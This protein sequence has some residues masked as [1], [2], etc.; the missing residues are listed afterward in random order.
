MVLIIINQA[1]KSLS[2]VKYRVQRIGFSF[3][4]MNLKELLLSENN[5][6]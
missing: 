2:L 3:Y 1:N 5:I 6:E 4:Q